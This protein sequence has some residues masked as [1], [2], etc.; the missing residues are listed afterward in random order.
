MSVEVQSP[1]RFQL[2]SEPSKSSAKGYGLPPVRSV[3][4]QAIRVPSVE[5]AKQLGG[6]DPARLLEEAG[7]A[8]PGPLPVMDPAEPDDLP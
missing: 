8:F 5:T 4:I 3:P 7:L 1:S 2:S 6:A